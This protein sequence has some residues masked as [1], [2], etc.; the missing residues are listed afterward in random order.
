MSVALSVQ[1]SS[2]RWSPPISH[3]GATRSSINKK[4][5]RIRSRKLYRLGEDVMTKTDLSGNAAPVQDFWAIHRATPRGQGPKSTPACEA[6]LAGSS[7]I[8]SNRN[9]HNDCLPQNSNILYH[10]Y[11]TETTR[12]EKPALYIFFSLHPYKPL[13]RFYIK[14]C[15]CPEHLLGARLF[16]GT[17]KIQQ[18]LEFHV[19]NQTSSLISH[20]G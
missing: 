2:L 13:E 5:K 4:R 10:K 17:I 14:H 6:A 11:I 20:L 12:M 18:L 19:L 3:G 7:E 8:E 16:S 9:T 1:R 15:T